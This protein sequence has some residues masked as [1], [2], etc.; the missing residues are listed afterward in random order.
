MELYRRRWPLGLTWFGWGT[1]LE[2][3][4]MFQCTCE[5]RFLGERKLMQTQLSLALSNVLGGQGKVSLR[6]MGMD[7]TT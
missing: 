6:E 4:D 5:L 1:L 7:F 3:A 2:L